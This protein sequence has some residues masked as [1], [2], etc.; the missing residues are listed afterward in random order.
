VSSLIGFP[1]TVDERAARV[2]AGGVVALTTTSLLTDQPWLL[3]P[4]AGGFAARVLTGPKLSPLGRFA[5]KV[6]VPRLSGPPRPVAG[7]PKR[8]AQGM[9]LAMS[10]TSLTLA[11]L[12]RRRAARV[13]LGALIGASSLEAFAGICVAC[14]IFP[15]LARAGLV[16]D[17][18]CPDCVNPWA[19]LHHQSHD[20]RSHDDVAAGNQVGSDGQ[21]GPDDDAALHVH[22]VGHASG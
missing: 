17:E 1:D 3:A 5:T 9:G 8:L 11:L 20:H 13:V 4:V 19:R 18:A 2:V 16:S 21:A 7:P 22:A 10:T 15:F 14:K 6:V 12:G